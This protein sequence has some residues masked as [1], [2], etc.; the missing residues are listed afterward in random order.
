[1]EQWKDIENHNGY[2]AS[3]E[4]RIRSKNRVISTKT[5]IRHYKGKLLNG[6]P[7][8]TN[9]SRGLYEKISLGRDTKLW[10]HRIVAQTFIPNPDNLKYV[11]HKDNNGLNNKSS[12]LRWVTN[13]ENV[14]HMLESHSSKS[15]VIVKGKSLSEW[16]A[17]L[18]GSNGLLVSKRLRRGWCTDCSV[19]ILNTG[20]GGDRRTS[21]CT[22]KIEQS[23]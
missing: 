13:S 1:M 10:V 6:S 19:T 14:K 8:K 17:L 16:S 20:I 23:A 22:H 12:N 5:G 2:E 9:K 18:G 3:S 7:Q 11:D 15:Q 21:P 4:G